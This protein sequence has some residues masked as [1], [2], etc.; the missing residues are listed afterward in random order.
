MSLYDAFRQ[1][2]ADAAPGGLL[3]PEWTPDRQRQAASTALDFTPVVGGVKGAT[4]EWQAGNPWWAAFNAGTVPLD[5]MSAGLLGGTIRSIGKGAKAAIEAEKA[6]EAAKRAEAWSALDKAA[7][8]VGTK[9]NKKTGQY[10]GAPTAK[11]SRDAKG[12]TSPQKKAAIVNDYAKTTQAAL[13]AGIPPGYFYEEG[14]KALAR[15]TDS[16]EEAREAAQ[17]FGPTSTMVGPMQNT[18]YAVRAYDQLAMGMPINVGLYPNTLRPGIESVFRGADPWKGYKVDR[19]SDRLGGHSNDAFEKG[20]LPPNDQV[21]GYGVGFKQGFVPGTP[22]QVAWA[23]H[24]RELAGKKLNA[25]REAQGL[26]PLTPEQIQELHWQARRAQLRDIPITL[27]KNDTIQD[28]LKQYEVTH[29]WEAQPGLLSGVKLNMPEQDYFDA[30]KGVFTDQQGKD[31]LLRAMGARLQDPMQHGLGVYEGKAVPGAQSISFGGFTEAN[32]LDPASMARIDT[33]EALRQLMLGQDSRAAHILRDPKTLASQDALLM[34]TGS[35]MSLDAQRALQEAL[36]KATGGSAIMTPAPEGAHV[37]NIGNM[38]N[39]E[40]IAATKQAG[41]LGEP[42]TMTSI[43]GEVK[44]PGQLTREL[45]STIDKYPEAK[46]LR[47]LVESPETR[48]IAGKLNQLYQRLEQQGAVQGTQPLRLA[49]EALQKHGVKGL[50]DLVAKGLAPA[51]VL[52]VL[53]RSEDR[54]QGD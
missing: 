25:A 27:G 11:G 54:Q 37:L 48:E 26:P 41:L 45:L 7:Q 8:Y 29:S 20:L 19:Y 5:L 53:P 28:A 49:L 43:Y 39:Q 23:D 34:N 32:G 6:A 35:P 13:D 44:K 31:A 22:T 33:T 14:R 24:I 21:E 16:P 15:V 47:S 52:S 30:V 2:L 9:R 10:I 12:V 1:Y 17:L 40:F 50:E 38:P 3:N 36:D 46:N 18:G 42:K 51:L 4:E